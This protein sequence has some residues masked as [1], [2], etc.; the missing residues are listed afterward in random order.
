MDFWDD[1]TGKHV[2]FVITK[3]NW[4]GAQAYVY[5]LATNFKRAAANVAVA[6]GDTGHSE[7][8]VGL[9]AERLTDA[10]VRVTLLGTLSRDISLFK[11]W[12]ALRE[13]IA[14]IR[15]ERPDVLH[16]NSSKAGVLGALAGRLARVPRIVFTAHGWAHREP[17][18]LVW[19]ILVWKASWL[20]VLLSHTVIVVSEHDWR[21]APVLFSRRKIHVV[22]NGIASSP[23]VSKSEARHFLASDLTALKKLPKWVLIP[24]ELTRNKG[25]DLA[26][27]AFGSVS[28]N[29][30]D[31]A[32]VVVGSGEEH[33]TLANLIKEYGLEDHV[34]LRGFVPDVRNYLAAADVFL[35]PSRKEGLPLALLEAGSTGLPA[36]ASRTGGIP[37]IIDEDEN[38]LLV[39]PGDI[40][41]LAAALTRLLLNTEEANAFGA[42]LKKTIQEKFSEKEMLAKTVAVYTS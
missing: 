12:Q 36:V 14:C 18:S 28:S 30:D 31:V 27:R 25:I 39:T 38:G 1:L 17:R 8:T 32:L 20:T 21:T 13:L 15:R 19:R 11:E 2:L 16:L 40:D 10:D 7:S 29:I 23:Q 42:R 6:L 37:E 9:L 4:G 26:I 41:G 3:S 33:A 34:F 22:H 5:A 24:A 35:L